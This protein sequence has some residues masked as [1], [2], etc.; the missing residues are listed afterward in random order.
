MMVYVVLALLWT[1]WCVLHSAMICVPVIDY[2]R[3]RFKKGFRFYRLFFNLVALATMTPIALYERSINGG[4]GFWWQ[5]SWVV[6]QILLLMVAF[7]LF[8]SGARHYDFFQFLGIRQ[9]REGV[10]RTSLT[11]NDKLNTRGILGMIRHPWYAGAI[12]VVWA[13]GL[14]PAALITNIIL[15]VYL[16]LGTY[17]EERKL[18]ME[19]G[20]QYRAYQRR[21]PMFIPYR[22]LRSKMRKEEGDEHL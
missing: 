11:G 12:L 18:V 17:L 13:R 4:W 1:G 2:L 6:F 10:S 8:F 19:Y 21:V 15:T 5:G 7:F 20:E 9:I 14:T 16:I 22:L 3:A